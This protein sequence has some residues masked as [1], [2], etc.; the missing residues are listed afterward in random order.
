MPLSIVL[1]ERET[2]RVHKLFRL[3]PDALQFVEEPPGEFERG[4]PCEP[5]IPG[6]YTCDLRIETAAYS[7]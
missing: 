4:T 1:V 5:P 3:H 6:M 7:G 2:D